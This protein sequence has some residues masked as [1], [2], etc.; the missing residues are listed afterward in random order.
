[1]SVLSNFTLGS[2][3]DIDVGLFLIGSKDLEEIKYKMEK[4][5]L[6]Q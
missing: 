3:K 5:N 4:F 2:L 1:M 6:L